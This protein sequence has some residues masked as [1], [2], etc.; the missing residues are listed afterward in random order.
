MD[1]LFL[2]F[3][4]N[5]KNHYQANFCIL[6]FLKQREHITSIN[7]Y[8]DHA[9]FYTYLGGLVNIIPLTKDLLEDWKGEYNYLYRIKIKALE[10]FIQANGKRPVVYLDSDTFLYRKEL[11]FAQLLS[12]SIALMHEEEGK[13]HEQKSKRV[14]SMWQ[15]VKGKSFAGIHITEAHTMWNSGVIA[16]PAQHNLEAIQLALQVC[17]EMLKGGVTSFM[18]EQYA[19]SIALGY[20]YTIQ[21]AS[22]WVGHYW[23]TKEEWNETI[24]NFFLETVL[25]QYTLEQD[26]T[27]LAAFDFSSLPI[28]KRVK[29]TR[30]RLMKFVDNLF[31]IRPTAFVEVEK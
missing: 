16:I 3:G 28:R 29:N 31:P 9:E 21:P 12:Q 15:K 13:L 14:K 6:S 18:L 30:L 17:D 8:T 23:A 5:I 1:L 10:H 26:I 19:V 11:S 24:S 27:R 25:K 7:I 2:T 22:N 20:F 4:P